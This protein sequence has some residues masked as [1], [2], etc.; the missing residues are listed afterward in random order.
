M[1]AETKLRVPYNAE[2]LTTGADIGCARETMRS[3]NC[4]LLREARN[5]TVTALS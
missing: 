1:S 4:V 3:G 2:L 5:A